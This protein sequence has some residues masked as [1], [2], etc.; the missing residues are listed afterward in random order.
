MDQRYLTAIRTYFGM[1][2]L[3]HSNLYDVTR[4]I[5]Y[6]LSKPQRRLRL[7]HSYKFIRIGNL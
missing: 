4:S 1:R 7:G 2:W 3:I 5:L 6:D